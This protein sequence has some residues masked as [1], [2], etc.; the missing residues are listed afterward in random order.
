LEAFQ[1][2]KRKAATMK[3]DVVQTTELDLDE[4]EKKL[5]SEAKQKGYY[6]GRL[7]TVRS[8][9][10]PK[11]QQLIDGSGDTAPNSDGCKR[12]KHSEW[13][14]AGTW[15]ETDTTAWAKEEVKTWINKSCATSPRV[16]TVS[17]QAYCITSHVTSVNSV[18]GDAQMVVVRKKLRHGFNFDADASFK[19]TFTPLNEGEHASAE[20]PAEQPA[21]LTFKGKLQMPEISDMMDLKDLRVDVSWK[22]TSPSDQLRHLASTHVDKLVENVRAQIACFAEVYRTR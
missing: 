21:V 2:A 17:Q 16:L 22:G 15:E 14:E 9:N 7:G 12:M 4:D 6:H 11:P 19:I 8:D 10:A 5:L 20:Q 3:E 13:N 1:L 18:N